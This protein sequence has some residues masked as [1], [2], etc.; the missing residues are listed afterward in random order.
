MKTSDRI[1]RFL[2]YS[3][4]NNI[5][6]KQKEIINY[7]YNLP[8]EDKENLVKKLIDDMRLYELDKTQELYDG[9][10][11]PYEEDCIYFKYENRKKRFIKQYCK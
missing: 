4:Y 3:D 1:K 9:D 5:P 10:I 2:S 8:L 7:W 11:E 6:T